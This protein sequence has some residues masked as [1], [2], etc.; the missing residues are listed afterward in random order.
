VFT[1]LQVA[2]YRRAF[3]ICCIPTGEKDA[4]APRRPQPAN[5][6]ARRRVHAGSEDGKEGE[7]ATMPCMECGSEDYALIGDLRR[8]RRW[9]RAMAPSTGC[10]GRR[11]HP[12]H[13]FCGTAGERD[14]GFW[15]I[16]PEEESDLK[17]AA[18]SRRHTHHRDRLRDRR[19]RSL[20]HRLHA[21]AP[22]SLASSFRLVRCE[23]GRVAIRMDLAVR[24]DY[25][26]TVRG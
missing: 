7:P 19:W 23:R 8:R 18:I 3:E 5:A 2:S 22:A 15:K 20:C 12:E 24:F 4:G 6:S 14:H 17:P 1:L 25:G 21:A 11:S 10:A 16:A 13:V 9:S 26:R